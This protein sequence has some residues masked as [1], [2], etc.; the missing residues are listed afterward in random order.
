MRIHSDTL[1]IADIESALAQCK[2]DGTIHDAVG[3]DVSE[4]KASR[5]RTGAIELRI[6][7]PSGTSTFYAQRTV[8]YLAY[9]LGETADA[10]MGVAKRSGRRFS[11]QGYAGDY[12]SGNALRMGATWHEH[13]YLYEKLFEKDPQAIIGNYDGIDSFEYQVGYDNIPPYV[14]RDKEW[15]LKNW[16]GRAM[17]VA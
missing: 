13:F 12:M 5:K 8:D 4:V 1:T 17:E 2:A 11:R 16:N 15:A 7:A 9:V 14:F 10:V 6:G 3:I